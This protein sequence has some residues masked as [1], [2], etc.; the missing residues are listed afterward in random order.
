MEAN[1]TSISAASALWNQRHNTAPLRDRLDVLSQAV[2]WA[3]DL[4]LYQ[5]TQLFSFTLEFRPTLILELGRG[6]GNSTAVYTE[7][8]NH[9]PG[10]RVVSI[11]NTD[12]WQNEVLPRIHEV[13]QPGWE[14]PLTTLLGDILRMD[15]PEI[16]GNDQRVLLFWDAHGFDVAE[17][18]L[19]SILPILQ[20]RQHQILMHDMS[21]NRYLPETVADY[22]GKGIW[23]GGNS[24]ETRL[25]LGT[26]NSAVEQVV[27]IVDFTSRNRLTLHS[28]DHSLHTEIGENAEKMAELNT[29]LGAPYFDRSLMAH[30]VWFSMNER[31][32]KIHFPRFV[33]PED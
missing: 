3:N 30:W 20:P 15:Y 28:A 33:P 9:I 24:G 23:R 19:G 27:S 12:V 31:D 1:H 4:T 18:I 25:W 10:C 7:A 17:C 22:A 5:W 2:N 32:G 26:L 14:R 16:I 13:V 29:T 11:C 8:A 21:D 6:Y